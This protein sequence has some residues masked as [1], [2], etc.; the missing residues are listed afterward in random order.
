M[1]A[2][3]YSGRGITE[4][5]V[6]SDTMQQ[7]CY[8]FFSVSL[9]NSAN[10]KNFCDCFMHFLFRGTV[11]NSRSLL[12]RSSSIFKTTDP[13]P[14]LEMTWHNLMTINLKIGKCS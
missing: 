1:D 11:L 8:I 3:R 2:K 6:L 9:R 5:H 10:F 13:F 7:A 4:F 12:Q 14:S